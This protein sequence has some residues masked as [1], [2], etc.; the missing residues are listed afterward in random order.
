VQK[1]TGWR[2]NYR[3]SGMWDKNQQF[4]CSVALIPTSRPVFLAKG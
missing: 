1:T 3:G 4:A 2:K